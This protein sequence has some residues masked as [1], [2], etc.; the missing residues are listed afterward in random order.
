M[1]S[2]NKVSAPKVGVF[3]SRMSILHDG[4]MML[5]KT[6]LEEN[7]RLIIFIGSS[8][9]ARS[10]R[11]PFTF[12]ERQRMLT[13]SIIE[14]GLDL[15]RVTV[16]PLQDT[17]ND[18]VW[19]L[20]VQMAVA[21]TITR[22]MFA[23]PSTT[24]VSIYFSDKEESSAYPHW[25]PTYNRREIP[26]MMDTFIQ[27]PVA[28]TDLRETYFQ[29]NVLDGLNQIADVVPGP[30][31]E[32]LDDFSNY[33]DYKELCAEQAYYVKYKKDTTVGPYG[34]P[35][36]VTCD[37]VVVQSGHILLIERKNLPGK[38]LWALPGGFLE[39]SESLLSGSI[40]ELTEET[41]LKVPEKVLRGSLVESDEF[42]DPKR[43]ERGRVITHAFY[44]KLNDSMDLPKVKGKSDAKKAMWVPLWEVM[45]KPYMFFED[46]KMIIDR[47]IGTN[48]YNPNDLI[49]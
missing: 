40:R 42:A 38:G 39:G 11:N 45:L 31:L 20:N 44:F 8:F 32:F 47:F 13:E 27:K 5:I 22:V 7:E 23:N 46:H 34:Q 48:A 4:H 18:N 36:F 12:G 28:A 33:D 6:A 21:R 9:R 35:N 30:V 3:I 15:K 24:D 16:V 49:L 43:S 25:F 29:G 26:A 41:G 10:P 2:K 1:S 14:A 17:Y 19:I 37:A